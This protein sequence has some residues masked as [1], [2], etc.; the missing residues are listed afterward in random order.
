MAAV[1]SVPSHQDHDDAGMQRKEPSAPPPPPDIPIGTQ[2]W[3]PNA[4][5]PQSSTSHHTV[6]PH[7]STT[8]QARSTQPVAPPS[9]S[10]GL[11]PSYDQAISSQTG[12]P[13]QQPTQTYQP[14]SSVP[15]FDRSAKPNA[16]HAAP[17]TGVPQINRD[18]KPQGYMSR[19][20]NIF[21][22]V[23]KCTTKDHTNLIKPYFFFNSI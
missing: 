18:A 15:E 8:S 13:Q 20:G 7:L 11:P 10:A 21:K 23:A 19:Q 17:N 6:K 16:F 3:G 9:N 2:I 5:Q 12:H 4:A 14:A 1:A 22:K